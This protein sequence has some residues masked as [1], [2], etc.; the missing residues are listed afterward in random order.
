MNSNPDDRERLLFLDRLSRS[1][2][3]LLIAECQLIDRVL[4]EQ[5]IKPY[6]RVKIDRMRQRFER[7]LRG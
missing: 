4:E 5:D 6:E 2:C 3:N 1:N 7:E